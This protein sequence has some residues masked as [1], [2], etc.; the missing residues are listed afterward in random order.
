MKNA[1]SVSEE[2]GGTMNLCIPVLEDKG[3]DSEVSAHFGS[4]PAFLVVDTDAM[5]AR[6]IPNNNLHHAHGGCQPLAALAGQ[7]IQGVVVGGIGM[8]ALMKLRAGGIEV[9]L[10][11]L[12]TARETVAAFKAGT[13]RPVDPNRSC[14]GHGHG[15]GG[16]GH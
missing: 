6:A 3:L 8:G 7:D 10:S 16:C 14:A 5:T 12:P 15:P 2:S 13:L 4:A 9:Y 11:E 1:D